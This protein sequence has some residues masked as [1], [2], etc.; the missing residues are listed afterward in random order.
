MTEQRI[1]IGRQR[2]HLASV[3]STNTIAASHANDPSKHG[4]VV[5]AETQTLG[6]GQYDRVWQAPAGS[7][8]L[9]SVLLFPIAELRRPALLT[10]WAAVA[11]CETILE[12]TGL[13]ARIKWPNDVLI[14]GKKVCG[15]LCEA[16]ANHLV[17]GIGVNVNQT[18]DDFEKM[19]LPA[20]SSLG[21]CSERTF[22]VPD[23]VEILVRHLDAEYERI[24]HGERTALEA[25][26]K[27]RIGLLGR[28]VVMERMDGSEV[29]GRLLEM[30]FDGIIIDQENGPMAL[31][32]EAIRHIRPVT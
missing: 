18:L 17:A 7:S 19:G 10:A 29:E 9:M 3:A 6:R 14:R 2:L 5:T 15:I 26:W 25:D 32:P 30:A 4:L 21:I 23:L 11:V 1:P 16:G 24:W 31:P 8:I 12:A 20:A 28:Q 27:W 13:Q 22:E